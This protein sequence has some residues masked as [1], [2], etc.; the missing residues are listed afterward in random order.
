MPEYRQEAASVPVAT[1]AAAP[2]AHPPAP[3]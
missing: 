3:H 1:P 2:A